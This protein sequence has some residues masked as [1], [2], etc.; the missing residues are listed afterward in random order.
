MSTAFRCCLTVVLSVVLLTGCKTVPPIM[1]TGPRTRLIHVTSNGWH[2]A[3]VVPAPALA[4][5]GAIP[6]AGDFSDAAF[7]EFGWGDRIYYPAEEKTVGMTLTAALVP[8]AGGHARSWVSGPT[9]GRHRVRVDLGGTDRGRVPASRRDAC[10]RVRA[11]NRRPRRAHLPRPLSPQLLLSRTR[12][13]SSV[14]HMQHMDRTHAA[15]ERRSPFPRPE[16]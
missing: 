12:G 1:D 10:G 16:S 9:R 4:T 6:E 11:S 15:C 13:F 3:I 7:L 5:T 8:T 2:T 14:Q